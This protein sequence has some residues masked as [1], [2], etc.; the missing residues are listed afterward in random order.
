LTR[1]IRDDVTRLGSVLGCLVFALSGASCSVDDVD[2]E[3]KA[4]TADAPCPGGY[5]CTGGTCCTPRFVVSN[6]ALDW[7]TPNTVRLSWTPPAN[8]KQ[9]FLTYV[10]VIGKSTAELRDAEQQALA[11]PDEVPG[12]PIRTADDNPELGQYDLRQS[13]EFDVVEATSIDLLEPATEYRVKLLSF[14]SSGCAASTATVA[15]RTDQDS[16]LEYDLFHETAQPGGEP[17]PF[18]TATFASNASL[19]FDGDAYIDW[20]GTTLEGEYELIGVA[21][22]NARLDPDFPSLDFSTAFIEAAV[23]LEGNPLAAWGEVRVL[24]GP[25]SGGCSDLEAF[26]LSPYAFRSGEDYRV[27]QVP[28]SQLVLSGNTMTANDIATRP[29]CEVSVGQ[30]FA[31]GQGVRMDEVRLRW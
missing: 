15:V 12:G 14:D 22:L 5:S 18:G 19:A 27:I 17:R 30:S 23:A 1:A 29:V 16:S 6:F 11:G 20:P 2:Y 25:A 26:Q 7:K 24:L 9:D 10:V 21:Q 28:L 4:C 3:G 31:A 8:A 13:S